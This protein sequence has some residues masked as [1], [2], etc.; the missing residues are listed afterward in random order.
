MSLQGPDGARYAYPEWDSDRDDM[1]D[2]SLL[3]LSD[4]RGIYIPRDFAESIDPANTAGIR[5]EDWQVLLAGP[6][7]DWYWEAWAAVCDNGTVQST[8]DGKVY[9]IYQGGDCW[10]IPLERVAP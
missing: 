8:V 9:A 6:D 5:A 7:H 10:L 4:A 3:F 1:P 2:G